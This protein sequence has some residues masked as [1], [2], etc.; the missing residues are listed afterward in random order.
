MIVYA[1]QQILVI[2][3]KVQTSC[4]KIFPMLRI[5]IQGIHGFFEIYPKKKERVLE[6]S[7]MFLEVFS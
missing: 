2:P 3:R 6:L 7:E 4:I 1:V 5:L